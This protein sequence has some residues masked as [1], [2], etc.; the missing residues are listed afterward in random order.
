MRKNAYILV[1]LLPNLEGNAPN[2]KT[3]KHHQKKEN[4]MNGACLE[5]EM[6]GGMS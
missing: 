5:D 1:T 2:K 4:E 6:D 3:G